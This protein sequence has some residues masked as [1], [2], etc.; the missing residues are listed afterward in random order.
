VT[1]I[2]APTLSQRGAH[3][4]LT[5]PQ[6]S[7]DEFHAIYD[8]RRALMKDALD[9]IGFTYGDPRGAFYVFANT[10]STG[11]NATEFAYQL[12]EKGRV[13]VFPGAGFGAAW[14]DYVRISLLQPKEKLVK[15]LERLLDASKSW[16]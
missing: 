11:L 5:G 6:T 4:A 14:E 10:R 9:E 12:L 15:A 7:V 1:N 8:E 16:S 3:A 13:L 2:A